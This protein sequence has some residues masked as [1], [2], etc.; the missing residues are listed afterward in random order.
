MNEGVR[1]LRSVLGV[2]LNSYQLGFVY[3]LELDQKGQKFFPARVR[4]TRQMVVCRDH[5][6]L[7]DIRARF[8][9]LRV[10]QSSFLALFSDILGI[11]YC[12]S[13]APKP[14]QEAMH[15][16]TLGRYDELVAGEG[17]PFEWVAIDRSVIA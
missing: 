13:G 3:F 14:E 7:N 5:G 4:E 2:D 1:V 17:E 16:L 8:P 12:V 9:R 11:A 15:I 10:R 6:V